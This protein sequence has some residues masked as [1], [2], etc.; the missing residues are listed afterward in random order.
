MA[1]ERK[2]T[3]DVQEKQMDYNFIFFLI[4]AFLN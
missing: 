4:F 2:E 1:E 3:F